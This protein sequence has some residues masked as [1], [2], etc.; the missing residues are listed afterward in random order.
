MR[1]KR[2]IFIGLSVLL[3][4]IS[5]I[6]CIR[7]PMMNTLLPSDT[8]PQNVTFGDRLL[9]IAPHP[10][11]ETL[12]GGGAILK[13][14]QARRQVKVVIMTTGDG[15]KKAAQEQFHVTQ[16]SPGEFRNLG[17][18]RHAESVRAMSTMGVKSSDVVF[19]GYPDG[20]MNSLWLNNWDANNLHKG[21]NGATASPYP[22]AFEAHA[23]YCGT[24]VVKNLMEVIRGYQPTDI[25]YP[26]P[27]D[28]HHD[29]W[30]T[31]AFVK[32]TLTLM[33]YPVHEWTYLVHRYDWPVPWAY[34]PNRDQSPPPPL[35]RVGTN[36]HA[37]PLT[38][39]EE[40]KKHQA[41]LQ[42]NSQERVMGGFLESFVRKN[43]LLGTYN[44]QE[45]SM[46]QGT[47]DFRKTGSLPYTILQD[48][49]ADTT[50]RVL[51]GGADL[52]TVGLVRTKQTIW[53]AIQTHASI[54]DPVSYFIHIRLFDTEDRVFR[55]DLEIL[56]H[57]LHHHPYASNSVELIHGETL[58]IAGNRLILSFPANSRWQHARTIMIS[59]DTYEKKHMID[60]TAWQTVNLKS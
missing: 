16:P 49:I 17:Y 4:I 37:L 41:V 28:V 36:W 12:G 1:K 48:P 5:T 51:H 23:P 35:R 60:K 27:N 39:L 43:D 30:A 52:E 38:D 56:N 47:P 3:A 29:H 40:S 21:L 11:D 31:H 33:H 57:T 53:L 58:Q 19:F 42:Y 45:I 2:Q 24:N 25:V 9:V 18:I 46:I 50:S 7:H 55:D 20:G 32:Y 54:Q 8:Y 14:L 6:A 59:A 15:Y 34:E 10:D 13:Q 44:R 26:D 22:F